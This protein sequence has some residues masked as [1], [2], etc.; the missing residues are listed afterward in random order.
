MIRATLHGLLFCLLLVLPVRAQ[1][2][3]GKLAKPHQQLE[4]LTKC[5]QC[6]ELGKPV[7]GARCLACHG[8]LNTRIQAGKGFH[9]G[10]RVKAS[11]CV[12]CHSDHHGRDFQ[13]I[14]W[15]KGD[16]AFSHVETGWE[17]EGRHSETKCRDCHRPALMAP[18]TAKRKDLNPARS[19]LGLS[20]DCRACHRDEHQGQLGTNCASCHDARD[21]NQPRF[22]HN[23]ARFAL[24]GAHE[25]VACAACHKTDLPRAKASGTVVEKPAAGPAVR[26]KP[27]AYTRCTD[28]HR[29][30]HEGQ[31]GT[32]CAS[33]HNTAS[34]VSDGKAFDHSRTRYPLTGAH[35]DLTCAQ[36]HKGPEP[37][38]RKPRFQDCAPCHEDPHAG[39][40]SRTEPR[41]ACSSCHD[42]RRFKPSGFGLTQHQESKAPLQGAH[43]AVACGDCHKAAQPAEPLRFRM[44]GLGFSGQACAECHA[45]V[46]GGQA[47]PWLGD[48][49]CLACHD[50]QDWPV[51]GFDH[52]RTEFALQ[53]RHAQAGCA[54]CHKADTPPVVPLKGLERQCAGCHEDPHRGQFQAAPGSRVDCALCHT[55]AGWK[56]SIFSHDKTRFP[57]D[58]RHKNVACAACH[59]REQDGQ[60]SFV[61][62]K[63]LGIR[64]EDCH[65]TATED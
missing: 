11:N 60:G 48:A 12:V 51:Q 57:L 15:E 1:L 50:L 44:A 55:P 6:H 14:F 38:R 58:G 31:L 52:G 32:D 59:L 24:T 4:G 41:R 3:P 47:K 21:W 46:H 62:Y 13:L 18:E 40:F 7:D 56:E 17:L 34:F 33:C 35:Q 5:T 2:S 29:D 54:A 53:G 43:Q 20:G 63:P 19:Y 49:G 9:A 22:D 64:C 27:L 37:G 25:R 16:K 36:C 8:A 39:Q 10:K 30:P 28:C 23:K 45:D 65:G 26:Y 42:T 61:R